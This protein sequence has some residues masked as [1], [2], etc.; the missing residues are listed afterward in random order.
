MT[1]DL[2]LNRFKVLGPDGS[3][4][5]ANEEVYAAGSDPDDDA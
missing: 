5:L 1:G 2:L 4:Y 3:E